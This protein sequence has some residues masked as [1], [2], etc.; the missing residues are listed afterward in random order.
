MSTWQP[1]GAS[2][3]VASRISIVRCCL[4]TRGPTTRDGEAL[5]PGG[6]SQSHKPRITHQNRS[7]GIKGLS[8]CMNLVRKVR[9]APAARTGAPKVRKGSTTAV[10]AG[11]RHL[12]RPTPEAGHA[13]TLVVRLAIVSVSA[14]AT[15]IRRC[16]A[17]RRRR[18]TPSLAP[19]A[20]PATGCRHRSEA[21]SCPIIPPTKPN[22]PP[23]PRPRRSSIPPPPGRSDR[24]PR[25]A[26]A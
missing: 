22:P 13:T 23:R 1:T 26:P 11:R 12:N 21:L 17:R 25:P 10:R 24:S 14:E 19:M 2:S 6:P 8:R 18:P 20:S 9:C 4:H 7:L 3:T 15:S 16:R 5:R